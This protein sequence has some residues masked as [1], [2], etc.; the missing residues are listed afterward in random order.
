M[1]EG[2]LVRKNVALKTKITVKGL[3]SVLL[4]ASAVLLPQIV[5]LVGG[6]PGGV[7]WLPMY[8]P[9]LV[10]GCLLG[11]YWGLGVGILSP[12]V[13][14]LIT[15]AV[16]NPMP[17]LARLPFMIAEL[18]VFASVS[19][20]FGKKISQNM[21]MA[22]PAVLIAQISGRAAFMLLVAIFQ[23]VSSLKLAVVWGQIQTGL[24]GLVLQ[25]LIVPLI[26]IGLSVLLNKDKKSE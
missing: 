25:A 9:V 13:S 10:A 3:I 18:A 24:I 20:L 1:I 11:T 8:L 4:I 23:N 5:H 26:I 17:A 15:A 21:W 22:F 19:G 14:F 12:V 7:K 16:G 6:V 2:V